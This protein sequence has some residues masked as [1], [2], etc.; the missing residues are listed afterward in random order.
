MFRYYYLQNQAWRD[1]AIGLT[2][3]AIYALQ[4]GAVAWKTR[5]IS[6]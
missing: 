5:R 1:G 2:V 6:S 3:S 4:H